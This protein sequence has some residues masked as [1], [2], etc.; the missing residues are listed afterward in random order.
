M[1]QMLYFLSHLLS[2]TL[3]V[4]INSYSDVPEYINQSVPEHKLEVY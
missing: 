2:L 1:W 3:D 4:F